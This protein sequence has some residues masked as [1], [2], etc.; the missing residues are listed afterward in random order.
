MK[1][2]NKTMCW[3]NTLEVDGKTFFETNANKV[4]QDIKIRVINQD[5]CKREKE[6]GDGQ[7]Y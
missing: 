1:G 7:H 4:F 3:D 5:F 2:K 6:C